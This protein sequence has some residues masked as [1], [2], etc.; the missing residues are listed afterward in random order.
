[1]LNNLPPRPE[2]AARSRQT[3][4]LQGG[5][6]Q[7]VFNAQIAQL[8]QAFDFIR[9][10]VGN[11]D[12]F[13]LPRNRLDIERPVFYRVS[14]RHHLQVTRV[15]LSQAKQFGRQAI[16]LSLAEDPEQRVEKIRDQWVVVDRLRI[17][18]TG[19]DGQLTPVQW[20]AIR[21]GD[22]VEV[23]ITFN[24]CLTGVGTRKCYIRPWMTRI[25]R[26][27]SAREVC[28]E[29]VYNLQGTDV[30]ARHARRGQS[31]RPC[32]HS[33]IPR[34]GRSVP[35]KQKARARNDTR[36]STIAYSSLYLIHRSN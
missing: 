22:F 27:K 3:I 12:H 2:N 17:G 10:S 8:Q 7:S 13:R 25:V 11:F 29:S 16:E 14:I 20:H 26:L 31:N 28:E 19:A 34:T 33:G 15:S 6:H 24:I 36:A 9:R 32:I 23:T 18:D 30:I 21:P 4:S 35:F 1:M 5:D